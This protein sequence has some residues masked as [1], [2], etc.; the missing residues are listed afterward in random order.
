MIPLDMKKKDVQEI[1]QEFKKIKK[2]TPNQSSITSYMTNTTSPNPSFSVYFSGDEFLS[3]DEEFDPTFIHKVIP[4]DISLETLTFVTIP[5]WRKK[6][7]NS[8]ENITKVDIGQ[9]KHR[10]EDQ[11]YVQIYKSYLQGKI[12]EF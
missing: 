8:N 2:Q 11:I 12:F 1:K 7:Q 4:S 10:V 3:D 5:C 9:I 6:A